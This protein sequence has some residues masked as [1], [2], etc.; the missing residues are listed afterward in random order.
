MKIAVIGLGFVGLVTAT[1]LAGQGNSVICIDNDERKTD[2][3]KDGDLYIYEPGLKELLDKNSGRMVFT[4]D[5][6][7]LKG[8]DV[9][10][11]CVPTP[12]AN[13]RIN[14]SYVVDSVLSV[15]SVDK[16]ATIAVKSTVVPGTASQLSQKIKRD[17]VSNPEFLREGNAIED[18][19]HP[20]RIVL[21]GRNAGDIEKVLKAWEFTGATVLKTTN[22]NAE[23]IKY[24]SNA[25][26]AT[27]ISFINE[28]AN[29]CENIP[30]ADVDVVAQGMGM[31]HRIGKEFL[32]AGIGFGGSC[33]PKDTTA[34]VS[35]AKEKGVELKIVKSAIEV[36]EERI[37]HAVGM[38]KQE[39]GDLRGKKICILGLAFKDN[40][41]DLR[42]SK[43]IELI[44]EL[45]ARGANISAYDPV[46]KELDE[47]ETVKRVEDCGKA[48]CIVIASEWSEFK[49][50]SL[51]NSA[52]KVIDLRKIVNLHVHKNVRAIG[53]YHA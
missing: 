39:L 20:D 6:S 29:L 49:T 24:A 31:D 13:G 30:G 47:V 46:V 35:Y 33:F 21:G 44:N 27:K 2:K 40:T 8:S 23:L 28:I 1:V 34:L 19:I 51:Y 5:Y 3:L 4:S 7:L 41:N 53:V 38:I 15:N 52:K 43:S 16:Y 50:N 17:V 48:D 36:N 25:F 37:G 32:R 18:T 26:L 10:F 45:R 12:N 9:A 14:L 11:I 22:E 42:E